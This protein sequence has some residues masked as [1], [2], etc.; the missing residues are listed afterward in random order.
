MGDMISSVR[1]TY[2]ALYDSEEGMFDEMMDEIY[3]EFALFYSARPM[4]GK[5]KG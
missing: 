5:G 1:Q 4:N 2:C 3:P